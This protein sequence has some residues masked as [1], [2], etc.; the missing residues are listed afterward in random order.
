LNLP[1]YLQEFHINVCNFPNLC[2]HYSFI[3]DIQ[4]IHKFEKDVNFTCRQ[5]LQVSLLCFMTISSEEVKRVLKTL[6]FEK[7]VDVVELVPMRSLR[8]QFR[9]PGAASLKSTESPWMSCIVRVWQGMLLR[10]IPIFLMIA[11]T[12]VFGFAFHCNS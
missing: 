6:G 2:I 12:A 1:P 5:A 10:R 11:A 8:G 9:D 7:D 3:Q 4:G